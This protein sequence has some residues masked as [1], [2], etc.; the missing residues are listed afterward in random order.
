MQCAS[1]RKM[2]HVSDVVCCIHSAHTIQ[3]IGTA[4]DRV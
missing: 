3:A 2:L 4:I 1:V